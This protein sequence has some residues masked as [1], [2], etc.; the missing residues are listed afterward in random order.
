MTARKEMMNRLNDA[1]LGNVNGGSYDECME[2]AKALGYEF[3]VT[4]RQLV[5]SLRKFNV[6]PVVDPYNGSNRY[7]VWDTR[8]PLTHALRNEPLYV[9]LRN[10]LF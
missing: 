6:Q 10:F 2:I 9:L 1:T 8:E 7:Y 4:V 5:D 3:S